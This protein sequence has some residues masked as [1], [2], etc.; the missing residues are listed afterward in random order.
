MKFTT[1]LVIIEYYLVVLLLL[2]SYYYYYYY[3]YFFF[4]GVCASA[5]VEKWRKKERKENSQRKPK[6]RSACVC[7]RERERGVILAKDSFLQKKFKYIICKLIT[8]YKIFS[9]L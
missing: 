4:L 3:Y 6:R 7:V 8:N 2:P 1:R 9:I 5:R